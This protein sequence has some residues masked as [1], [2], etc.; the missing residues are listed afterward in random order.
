GGGTP[1]KLTLQTQPSATATAGVPFTQQPVIRVEDAG[2]N[3]VATDNGRVITVARS[4]GT[5]ALQGTLTATTVNGLAT[6]ANLSYNLAETI[7]L[8][9]TAPSLTNVT[10]GNV[11]VGTGPF[12]KLQLLAPG[13]TA[14]PGTASGK[15][16]TPSAQIANSSFGVT[17]NAVDVFYNAANT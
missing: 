7:N 13:E 3:L 15:T 2:G 16:G 11:S 5:A 12:S 17:L 14:A 1:R 6:F 4:M 10:S 8:N 9:F